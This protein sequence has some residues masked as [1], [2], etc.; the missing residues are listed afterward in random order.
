MSIKIPLTVSSSLEAMQS[1]SGLLLA[2]GSAYANE[3][4]TAEKAPILIAIKSNETVDASAFAKKMVEIGEQGSESQARFV[5]NAM[6]EVLADLTEEYGAI[7]VNIPGGQISTYIAGTLDYPNS[8]IDPEKNYP[9]LGMEVDG[10]LQKAIGNGVK[11]YTPSDGVPA[12]MSYVAD[13]ETGEK[14]IFGMKRFYL[15]GRGM[16]IGGSGE[17]IEL[18][19]IESGEKVCDVNYEEATAGLTNI[20]CSLANHVPEAGKYRLV[21]NTSGGTDNIWPITL[22][23]IVETVPETMKL[24]NIVDCEQDVGVVDTV[25]KGIRMQMYGENLGTFHWNEGTGQLEQATL[26]IDYIN[27]NGEAVH[28]DITTDAMKTATESGDGYLAIGPGESLWQDEVKAGTRPTLT[29]INLIDGVSHS[30]S[31]AFALVG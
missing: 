18:Y 8:A 9:Y 20:T 15:K 1:S 16:T 3:T 5:I 2:A 14:K 23:V 25:T 17:S 7:T 28:R 21:F 22:D 24:T 31:R 13:V 29:F 27:T 12:R 30:A 26:Y 10:T 4:G 19:D 11:V 6:L